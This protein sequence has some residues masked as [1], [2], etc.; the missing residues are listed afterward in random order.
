MVIKP[1]FKYR[2]NK[3]TAV[4]TIAIAAKVSQ[5]ITKI[6]S[7]NAAPL[8]PT[9]C[10][11]DKFVSSKEPAI[12]PAVKLLPP[13]KYP[14]EL[15]SFVFLV[16]YHDTIATTIVKLKKEIIPSIIIRLV[17]KYEYNNLLTLFLTNQ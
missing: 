1:L 15:S 4:K 7:E 11:V 14:S 6:P 3:K 12:T 13:K 2:G 16:A 5:A 10:S 17:L 9:I 8:S